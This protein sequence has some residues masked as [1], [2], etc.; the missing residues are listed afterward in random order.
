MGVFGCPGSYSSLL[1]EPGPSPSPGGPRTAG[2]TC[3]PNSPGVC[4][5][6][7]ASGSGALGCDPCDRASNLCPLREGRVP[8]WSLHQA[9]QS[10][11]ASQS[12]K[13]NRSEMSGEPVESHLGLDAF[14]AC[15][16]LDLP[17]CCSS[18]PQRD[19]NKGCS[20][21][22]R[23]CSSGFFLRTCW[24]SWLFLSFRM[25]FRPHSKLKVGVLSPI[26]RGF[27]KEAGVPQV[28]SD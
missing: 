5:F 4:D 17:P 22:E 14:L 27:G 12:M 16:T 24:C 1:P 6:L 20:L 26:A 7:P 25:V 9:L 23:C 15:S 10:P 21:T 11:P 2:A 13:G 3:G 19:Q 8:L 28:G 18:G